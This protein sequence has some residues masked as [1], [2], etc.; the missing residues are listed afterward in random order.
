MNLHLYLVVSEKRPDLAEDS[1]DI[2]VLDEDVDPETVPLASLHFM[3]TVLFNSPNTTSLLR[4]FE[5]WW[6]EN[7][8]GKPQLELLAKSPERIAPAR[9]ADANELD[10]HSW[11]VRASFV[12]YPAGSS[13]LRAAAKDLIFNAEL[14]QH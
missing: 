7:G 11:V 9:V 2:L 6:A 13:E 5:S 4:D 14:L 12:V 1:E 10:E 8:G 3:T